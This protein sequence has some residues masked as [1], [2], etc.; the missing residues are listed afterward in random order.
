MYI[1]YYDFLNLHSND[2][3]NRIHLIQV[4]IIVINLSINLVNLSRYFYF[5][6]IVRVFYKL[7]KLNTRI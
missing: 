6:A 4:I 3:F 7:L 5:L 1:I 2:I